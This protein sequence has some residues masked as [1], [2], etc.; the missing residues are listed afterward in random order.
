VFTAGLAVSSINTVPAE[1][2]ATIKD[3]TLIIAARAAFTTNLILKVIYLKAS[4]G[5]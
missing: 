2:P 1:N 3:K 5:S 4:N